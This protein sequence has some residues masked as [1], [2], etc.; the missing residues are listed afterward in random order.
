MLTL[1]TP[2]QVSKH[3]SEIKPAIL[4]S[5]PPTIDVTP[6][7]MNNILESIINADMQVWTLHSIIDNVEVIYAIATTRLEVDLNSGTRNLTL[8]SLY[9]Y[10]PTPKDLWLEGLAGLKTFAEERGCS[11]IVAYTLLPNIVEL[12]KTLGADVNTRLLMWGI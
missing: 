11:N 3:W 6:E 8:F 5:M 2:L 12:A 4:V 10:R 9:G 1:L 7:S